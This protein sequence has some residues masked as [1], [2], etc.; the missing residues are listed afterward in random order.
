MA[1]I[2]VMGCVLPVVGFIA[3]NQGTKTK[4]IEHMWRVWEGRASAAPALLV[5][6][7]DIELLRRV[8][9]NP[10]DAMEK[11]K[12][13]RDGQASIFADSWSTWLGT[14]LTDHVMTTSQARCKG[15]LTSTLAITDA[16][17]PGWRATGWAWD[18]ERHVVPEKIVLVNQVSVVVGYGLGGF[19]T[20]APMDAAGWLGE[21]VGIV[22]DDVS[23]FALLDNGSVACPLAR[24]LP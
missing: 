5:G 17:N 1:K 20:P 2:V 10:K 15:A 21:F 6:V 7:A 23:A 12:V 13:L 4:V 18:N 8:S 9:F 16:D 19:H 24:S 22:P 14:K 3:F 11:R